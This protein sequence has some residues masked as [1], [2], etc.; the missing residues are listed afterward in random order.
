MGS[1]RI[2][3]LICY[4]LANEPLGLIIDHRDEWKVMKILW[5]T[6]DRPMWVEKKYIKKIVDKN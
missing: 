2:G 4:A 6:C 1:F 3:E 5:L